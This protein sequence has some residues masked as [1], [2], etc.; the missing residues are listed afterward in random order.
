MDTTTRIG[1]DL[2]ITGGTVT[3]NIRVTDRAV[4]GG[5][6]HLDRTVV[7]GDLL[8]D[9]RTD[10]GVLHLSEPTVITE[11]IGESGGWSLHQE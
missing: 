5:D 10:H 4:I 3:G 7:S 1:N 9:A 6:I 2:V 11:W 8:V